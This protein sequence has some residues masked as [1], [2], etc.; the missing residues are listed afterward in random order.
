MLSFQ[1][2]DWVKSNCFESVVI[3]LN[4]VGELDSHTHTPPPDSLRLYSLISLS[5]LSGPQTFT[6]PTPI[7]D[8]TFA[9]ED[10]FVGFLLFDTYYNNILINS[11]FSRDMHYIHIYMINLKQLKEYL[12]LSLSLTIVSAHKV[13]LTPFISSFEMTHPLML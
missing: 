1:K 9:C 13:L 7:H 6:E 2:I 10:L 3:V 8:R 4:S 12:S 5:S 11:M